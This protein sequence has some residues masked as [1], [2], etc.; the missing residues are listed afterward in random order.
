MSRS[1]KIA[2]IQF[3]SILGDIEK[4]I[5]KATNRNFS[6]SNLIN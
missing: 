5:K 2:L 1:I 6:K 3:S 4:N